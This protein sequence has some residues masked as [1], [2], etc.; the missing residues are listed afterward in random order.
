[1]SSHFLLKIQRRVDRV[2]WGS[3]MLV[4]GVDRLKLHSYCVHMFIF[5]SI[6]LECSGDLSTL[7]PRI[8]HS[9]AR[10]QTMN[11]VLEAYLDALYQVNVSN[12]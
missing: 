5:G 2:T 11:R 3:M 6:K 12:R 8:Q 10:A 4:I 7:S 1:M 9:R